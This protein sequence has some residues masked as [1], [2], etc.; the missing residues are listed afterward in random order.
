MFM[1]MKQPTHVRTL[2]AQRKRW[3]TIEQIA[4][5]LELHRNT[6]RKFLKGKNIDPETALKVADAVGEDVME[7]AEFVN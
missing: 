1:K 5:G 3:M 6:V 4:G 2:F 7:I